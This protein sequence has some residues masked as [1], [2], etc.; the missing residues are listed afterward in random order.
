MNYVRLHVEFQVFLLM[1]FEEGVFGSILV[2][3][4]LLR[5]NVLRGAFQCL[6]PDPKI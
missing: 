2:S 5:K 4:I 3:S 1:P 6:S